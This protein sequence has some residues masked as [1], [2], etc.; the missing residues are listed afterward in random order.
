YMMKKRYG[1]LDGGYSCIRKGSFQKRLTRSDID[2]HLKVKEDRDISTEV[3]V[4]LDDK[5]V[6]KN[7]ILRKEKLY[8]PS[9]IKRREIEEIIKNQKKEKTNNSL[10]QD[11]MKIRKGISFTGWVPYEDR[12]I[13]TLENDLKNLDEV[14]KEDDKY[15]LCEE[16]AKRINFYILNQS[17]NFLEGTSVEIVIPKSE[18]YC[19]M[20]H[21]Y[22][23]SVT[24][25]YPFISK[26]QPPTPS[27][28]ELGYP[29][30]EIN[31]DGNYRICSEIGN[32]KHKL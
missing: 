32:V 2:E 12:D 22:K 20:K 28:D 7:V 10:H 4:S 6:V 13:E 17:S 27:F 18:N 1:K 25:S 9:R 14:Y 21:I 15:Y 26:M 5:D 30:I 16:K 31:K 23:K 24:Y 11:L 29:N 8:F 3:F 19:I